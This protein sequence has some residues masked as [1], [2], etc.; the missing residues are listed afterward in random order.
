MPKAY[1]IR[2]SGYHIEDISPVLQRTDIIEKSTPRRAFLVETTGLE[3]VTPC[4]SS[5]CSSQLSYASKMMLLYHA[6]SH[7]SSLFY[8]FINKY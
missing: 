8:A 2:V 6:F 4:T 3:P 1:I 5:R 7:K